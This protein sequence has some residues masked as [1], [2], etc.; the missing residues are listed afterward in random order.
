MMDNEAFSDL[1][2]PHPPPS[3]PLPIAVSEKCSKIALTSTLIS[4]LNQNWEVIASAIR[5]LAK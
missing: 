2:S 1:V 4:K 5:Q 3:H